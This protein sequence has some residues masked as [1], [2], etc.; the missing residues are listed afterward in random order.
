MI[1]FGVAGMYLV[2]ATYFKTIEMSNVS[3]ATILQFTAPFFI[4]I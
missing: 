2:Q 3:F 1:L 4:F